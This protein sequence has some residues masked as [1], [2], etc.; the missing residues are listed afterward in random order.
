MK[1]VNRQELNEVIQEGITLVDIYADW[2]GPCKMVALMLDKI[3]PANPEV[4][5]V[6]VDADQE[7]ALLQE[8]QVGSIPT[9]LFFKDG[10]LQ[11]TLIGFQPQQKIQAAIDAL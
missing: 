10:E 1:Q 4:K 5:I 2:C 11:K 6:K 3:E 8:Y 9:L 7:G